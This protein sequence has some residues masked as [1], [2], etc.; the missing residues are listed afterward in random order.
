MVP[1]PG[2]E[3]GPLVTEV[4]AAETVLPGPEERL[5]DRVIMRPR[6]QVIDADVLEL[7]R[8]VARPENLGVP[9]G[10]D[11]DV[12]VRSALGPVE[13]AHEGALL[14][15]AELHHISPDWRNPQIK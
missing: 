1:V 9:A 14:L 6:E 15:R 4:D 8:V 5:T 3:S 2:E 12:R 11:H 13:C 7:R 10:R